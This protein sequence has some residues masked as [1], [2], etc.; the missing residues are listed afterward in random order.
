MKIAKLTIKNFL[1]LK[2]VEL[3]PSHTNVIV[4]KNKQGKTSI[5][6]A[7][8][9]AFE[10]KVDESS[11][12]IGES[13]AEIT[14][15]LDELTIKRSVTEKGS[16]LDVSTK[17]GY[18]VP[19]PQKFLDGI[20]GTFS[21][22]PI[23]FFEMKP[24]EQKAY[25]LQALPMRISQEE[26]QKAVGVFTLPTLDYGKHALDV[27]EE[28]RKAFYDRRTVANAEVTKKR[29]ALDDTASKIPDGF[30]P[31]EVSE[32]KI[33]ALRDAISKDKVER[34]KEKANIEAISKLKQSKLDVEA[35]IQ[36]LKE[37][38]VALDKEIEEKEA[39]TFDVSDD[40]T[41]AAAE[42]S[43]KSLEGKRDLVYAFQSAETLRKELGVAVGEADALDTVVKT[44]AKDV[45]QSLVE[46]AKLPVEGLAV[47]EDGIT[48]GGVAIENLSSSEQLKFAL[49][50]VRSLNSTFHIVC[51]DG[52]ERL[53]NET[54][55]NFLKE[56]EADDYQYF[57][58]RVDGAEAEKKGYILVEDGM[59][60]DYNHAKEN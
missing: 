19:T 17:E 55:E 11:I 15:E 38:S 16:Y 33:V 42:E 23:E 46:K 54:F 50:I 45:P 20:L 3:N 44:L 6:K 27:I 28:A 2:D 52:V 7:I 51:I 21:F 36:R 43:L 49:Q 57:V 8:Q 40:M 29:K 25:L 48:L 34:E 31:A 18:K 30:N 10:G 35:E 24:A 13:K 39:L 58:S 1:K 12:N 53:D 47:T 60:K 59:V 22:N 9:A 5:L 56:I 32:E 26:L 41:I 14:V 37:K 4:G